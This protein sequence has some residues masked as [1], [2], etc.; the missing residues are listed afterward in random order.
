VLT[1]ALAVA[2]DLLLVSAQ[3]ALTPWARARG[4]AA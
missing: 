4:G 1:V 2:L 3:R